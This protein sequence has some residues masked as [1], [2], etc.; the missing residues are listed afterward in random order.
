MLPAAP[1][2]PKAPGTLLPAYESSSSSSCLDATNEVSS[3]S[4]PPSERPGLVYV[5]DFFVY[6]FKLYWFFAVFHCVRPKKA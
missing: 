1:P 4:T 3:I 6:W 5:L 2:I